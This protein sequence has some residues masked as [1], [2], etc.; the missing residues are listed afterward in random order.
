LHLLGAQIGLSLARKLGEQADRESEDPSGGPTTIPALF[1]QTT[2]FDVLYGDDLP[3]LMQEALYEGMVSY[4][5]LLC[6]NDDRPVAEWLRENL[7]ERLVAGQR[8]YLRFLLAAARDMGADVPESDVP[9]DLEPLDIEAAER[10]GAQERAAINT[11][12]AT[13][14]ARGQS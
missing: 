6:L 7:L 3:P 13:A 10:A 2:L 4:V 5:S 12:L 9:P 14:R 1:T 11:Y 8:K